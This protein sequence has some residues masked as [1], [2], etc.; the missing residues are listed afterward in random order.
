MRSVST[1]AQQAASAAASMPAAPAS[2]PG[3]AT[4]GLDL[5]RGPADDGGPVA[6]NYPSAI[7]AP[8]PASP[9]ALPAGGRQ[10]DASSKAM[11]NN[12][13]G[14]LDAMT[15][16]L[17]MLTASPSL[18]P[19]QKADIKALQGMMGELKTDMASGKKLDDAVYHEKMRRYQAL[20]MKVMAESAA[21]PA[22]AGPRASPP[23]NVKDGR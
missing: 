11:E 6:A 9:A 2:A 16:M 20:L 1:L 21:A 22:G 7:A 3:P 18:K 17:N 4:S 5:L 8:A 10:L 15:P 12:A 19:E 13:A 14:M 23:Q